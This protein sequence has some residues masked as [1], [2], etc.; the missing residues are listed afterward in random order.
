[1]KSVKQGDPTNTQK[2][3][4]QE[5]YE[6]SCQIRLSSLPL[7]LDFNTHLIHVEFHTDITSLFVLTSGVL[8]I[9][10]IPTYM[11]HIALSQLSP[12]A[13]LN[14]RGTTAALKVHRIRNSQL[15]P[16]MVK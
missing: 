7:R 9:Y 4:F 12:F 10:R 8:R 14:T 1:M 15:L 16:A 5:I 3:T 2:S 6:T 11:P 13:H